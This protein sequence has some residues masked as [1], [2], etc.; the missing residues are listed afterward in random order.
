MPVRPEDARE[1]RQR[2]RKLGD[3]H[4]RERADHEIHRVVVERKVLQVGFVEL[5][6]RD[7][8][9]RQREHPRRR[10]GADHLVVQRGEVRTVATGP[11]GGIQG[12]TD[13]KAVEDL[14]HDRLFDLDHLVARL[15]V[16]RSPLVIRLDRRD[17][18]N[19]DPVSE[20]V[21]AV[22]ERLDLADAVLR[23]LPVICAGECPEQRNPFQTQEIRQR[24]LVNHGFG[25]G[26]TPFVQS[27][28]RSRTRP[29]LAERGEARGAG[30]LAGAA[31][32]ENSSHWSTRCPS[33]IRARAA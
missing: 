12:Y 2:S 10:V 16:V 33:R 28:C 11:V 7:P 26:T 23:E 22:Q 25:H 1:L 4:H 21:C 29:T 3:V 27:L 17:R 30:S 31:G 19:L 6:G 5:P 15:V 14:P 13:R 9:P 32:C 8:L 20:F 18:N 24:V